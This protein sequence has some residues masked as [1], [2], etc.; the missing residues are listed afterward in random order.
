MSPADDVFR[1]E[2]A[3]W[4][5]VFHRAGVGPVIS[6]LAVGEFKHV[7]AF[8]YCAGVRAWLVYDVQWAGTRVWLCDKVAIMEWT[9]DCAVVQIKRSDAVMGLAARLGLYCVSSVKHL[10]GLRCVAATPTQLYRHILRNG[11][12]LISGT[13]QSALSARRSE[14]A[15]RA[16]AGA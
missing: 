15:D 11:G 4:F 9:K 16:A 5:V 13:E 12:I 7:S 10:L 1:V 3:E 14:P 6:A 2:P 8:G